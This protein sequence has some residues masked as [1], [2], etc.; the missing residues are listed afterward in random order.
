MSRQPR[1]CD[2]CGRTIRKPGLIAYENI[3]CSVRCK[4]LFPSTV[5]RRFIDHY[6]HMAQDAGEWI[7]Q[8]LA[9]NESHPDQEPVDVE[10]LRLVKRGALEIVEALRG[11]APIPQR[12]LRLINSAIPGHRQDPQDEGEAME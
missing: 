6:R 11:W 10:S 9:W 7:D 8:T 4:R 1:R 12:A 5:R 2:H 3:F